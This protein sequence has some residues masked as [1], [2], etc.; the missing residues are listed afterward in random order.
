MTLMRFQISNLSSQ[1]G[2]CR[3]L[4]ERLNRPRWPVVEVDTASST[5]LCRADTWAPLLRVRVEEAF[6]DLLGSDC[7]VLLRWL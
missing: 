7:P 1:A 2:L 4:E 6:E 5:F 3:A